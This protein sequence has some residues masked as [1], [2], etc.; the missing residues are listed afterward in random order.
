MLPA[1]PLATSPALTRGDAHDRQ[2]PRNRLRRAADRY[3]LRLTKSPRR[4]PDALDYGLYAV[5]DV[6]GNYM[7]SQPLLG[8]YVHGWTLDQVE[9]YFRDDAARPVKQRG[10]R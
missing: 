5:I 2:S 6:R 3:G 9:D 7:V 10:G 1:S 4:D 8:H